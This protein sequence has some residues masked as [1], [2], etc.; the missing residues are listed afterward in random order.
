[1]MRVALVGIDGSGKTSTALKLVQRLAPRMD[2]CKPGRPPVYT[3]GGVMGDHEAAEA[4]A[5]EQHLRRADRTGKRWRVALAR[6][7]YLAFVTGVERRMAER[8]APDL[9]LTA[10]CPRLDPAVY[11]DFYFPRLARALPM[12]PRLGL[13][14][15][16][17]R[18]PRRD[19]YCLLATPADVAM[20]RIEKR[21]EDLA[22]AEADSGRE[23]W[24]HLHE[25]RDVLAGLARGMEQAL[26]LLRRRDGAEVMVV[27]NAL[28]RQ[29]G[30]VELLA[31][32]I[33]WS[34]RGRRGL[35]VPGPRPVCHDRISELPVTRV[36]P[37]TPLPAG[38]PRDRWV[39]YSARGEEGAEAWLARFSGRTPRSEPLCGSFLVRGDEAAGAWGGE[40]EDPLALVAYHEPS[41]TEV[42]GVMVDSQARVRVRPFVIAAAGD[43]HLLCDLEGRG[44]LEV[45][46]QEDRW[47]VTLGTW[48]PTDRSGAPARL[49]TVEVDLDGSVGRETGTVLAF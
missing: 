18:V 49:L 37:L 33:L 26:E 30:V 31:D 11:L 21:L 39:V 22:A 44:S 14:A 6:R 29:D 10:R 13:C 34:H 12:G 46:W 40:V 16:A 24:L 38:R 47:Q 9:M 27:D 4:R 25:Q 20:A 32:R 5:M 17:A 48:G 42:W 3:S 7:R 8:F 1:M 36:S 15:L 28:M 43:D 41:R 23:H 19:L 45:S 2:V 35:S